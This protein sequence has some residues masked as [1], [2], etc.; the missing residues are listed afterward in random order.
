MLKV[1]LADDEQLICSMLTRIVR[2]DALGL[3]LA[4]TAGDGEALLAMIEKEQPDIVVTD[5]CMPKMDGL[6]IIRRVRTAGG[7]CR[8]VIISG[9]RQFEYAYNALKYDVE[10]YIL[11]PVDEKELNAALQKIADKIRDADSPHPSDNAIR[12]YFISNGLLHS[13]AQRPQP[14]ESVNETYDTHFCAG[15]FRMLILK[16]DYAEG[17]AQLDEDTSSVREKIKSMALSQLGGL[18][19]DI[20][21]ED[22]SDGAMALLNYLPDAENRI[23]AALT[24]LFAAAKNIVDLF[25]GLEFTLCVGGPVNEI[26]RA[27]ETK[28]QARTASWARMALGTSRI[29][30][31]EKDCAGAP[32]FPQARYTEYEQRL[33]RAF[34]IMDVEGFRRCM[35]EF[36]ALPLQVLRSYE[37]LMFIRRV[38]DMFLEMN[39]KQISAYTDYDELVRRLNRMLHMCRSFSAYEDVII[40]QVSEI[41]RQILAALNSQNTRPVRQACAYLEAHYHQQIG[42]DEIAHEVNLSPV[43]FSNLFKKETG[44]TFTE[45][46]TEL[47]M[48]KAREMLK[49]GAMNVNEIADALGFADARYFSKLFKKTVGVKPTEYRKLYG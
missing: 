14:L 40:A 46:A 37:S 44:K 15:I 22:K 17:L 43:Y 45:Y 21:F 10:D 41:M 30:R 49:A 2:F 9:Y 34:E 33:H 8:F 48:Q 47:R 36:F 1:I 27:E 28:N 11:K 23:Q 18:C 35:K 39:E 12:A 7:K 24:E 3:E 19:A 5:I 26:G 31:Y 38:R 6:E 42:L 20:V 4:G 32:V 13:L 29:I 25:R 16:I